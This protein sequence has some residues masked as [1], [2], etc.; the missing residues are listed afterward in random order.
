M[1]TLYKLSLCLLLNRVTLPP[2]AAPLPLSLPLLPL[3]PTP[4]L[5]LTTLPPSLLPLLP[6]STL[7]DGVRGR[8]RDMGGTEGL[9]MRLALLVGVVL[10]L[11]VQ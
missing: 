11:V 2:P 1:A 3:W 8:L 7:R 6:L 5:T 4:A 9:E 10:V